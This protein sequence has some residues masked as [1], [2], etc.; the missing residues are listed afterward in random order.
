MSLS[1]VLW[2]SNSNLRCIR[3]VPTVLI[4]AFGKWGYDEDGGARSMVT[5]I[6]DNEV[7]EMMMMLMVMMILL[8]MIL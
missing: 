2:L 5:R 4:G 1:V 3:E 6:L 7:D 8:L